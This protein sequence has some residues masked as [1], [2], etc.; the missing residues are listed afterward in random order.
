MHDAAPPAQPVVL[1]IV[2]FAMELVAF[3]GLF[4]WGWTTGDGGI[5]GALLGA[6]FFLVAAILWGVLAVPNDPSRNPNP[7]IGVPGWLRLMIE[8]GI[9]GVAAYGIWVS[10]SRALAETLITAVVITYVLTYDRARWLLSQ[11]EFTGRS[12]KGS[13]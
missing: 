7:P 12:A 4:W 1:G 6:I 9:F 8:L 3:G 13:P 2:R 10:G 5:T 11:R